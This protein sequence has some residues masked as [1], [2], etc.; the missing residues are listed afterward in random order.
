MASFLMMGIEERENKNDRGEKRKKTTGDYSNKDAVE[1]VLRYITRT[2]FNEKDQHHLKAY[3]IFGAIGYG[4]IDDIITEFE[5][6][7]RIH[8]VTGRRLYHFVFNFTELEHAFLGKNYD[9]FYRIGYAQANWFFSQ[10]Y[11]TVFA[12]HDDI[13]KAV[14][15]HYA[16]NAINFIDGHKLHIDRQGTE[17]LNSTMNQLAINVYYSYT[18]QFQQMIPGGFYGE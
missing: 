4:S 18:G 14:H 15:I 2:R 5:N 9:L 7:L 10:G 11:Q 12:V 17:Q 1:K 13:D 16:V 8:S 6:V 3:G